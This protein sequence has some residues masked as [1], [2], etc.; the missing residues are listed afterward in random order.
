MSRR[1]RKMYCGQ[2]RLCVCLSVCLSAAACQQYCTDPDVTWGVVGRCPLV[3]HYWADLQSVHG[4]RCYGNITRTR[5]VS[6]YEY[7]LVL[8][9]LVYFCHV[10]RFNVFFILPS[11]VIRC[12]NIIRQE[13]FSCTDRASTRRQIISSELPAMMQLN[14]CTVYS[15]S[16]TY[17]FKLRITVWSYLQSLSLLKACCS[18]IQSG[19]IALLQEF[20]LQP[21]TDLTVWIAVWLACYV[22]RIK[23]C[24]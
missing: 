20:H 14:W 18:K 21:L 15:A 11:L 17:S 10:L 24:V 3:V 7:M 1:R 4:L 19:G 5:N 8:L 6:E 12:Y 9:C 2:A 13:L 23:N 22:R 16:E